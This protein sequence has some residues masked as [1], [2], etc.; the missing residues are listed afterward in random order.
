M[1]EVAAASSRRGSALPFGAMV[2]A[3]KR[4]PD[5]LRVLFACTAAAVATVFEPTY[6]TLS[7][8]VVQTWLRAPNSEAPMIL[9]TAFLTLALLTLLVGALADFFGRRRFLLLGLVGLTVSNVLCLFLLDAPR[10]F[11]VADI[12]NAVFGV[13][14]LP[15]AVAI[16]TLT[17]E[18]SIRPFAYGMLFGIQGAALVLASLFISMLGGVGGGRATFI[19]VLVAMRCGT[20]A[21]LEGRAREPR[22]RIDPP[23]QHHC[24]S[25]LGGGSVRALVHGRHGEDPVRED[26]GRNH[27]RPGRRAG[28]GGH[29]GGWAGD[30]PTSRVSRSMAG[31]MWAWRSSPD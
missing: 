11:A 9:T 21:R 31:A 28:R 26:S 20:G 4:N 7:T 18:P 15:A 22:T 8:S 5:D 17:F 10:T 19:P 2:E 30:C 27:R 23:R 12:L 3:L 25:L 29:C 1:S 13:M 16:V 24:E 6:L 14:V